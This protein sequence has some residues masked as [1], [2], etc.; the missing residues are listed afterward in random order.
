MLGTDTTYHPTRSF[1]SATELK[2]IQR[3]G[4]LKRKLQPVRA[5]TPWLVCLHIRRSTHDMIGESVAVLIYA[6]SG[7]PAHAA[8]QAAQI[9]RKVARD[10][11]S[12][13]DPWPDVDAEASMEYLD[14]NDFERI[15]KEARDPRRADRNYFAGLPKDPWLVMIGDSDM[16]YHLLIDLKQRGPTYGGS[17]QEDLAPE[18]GGRGYEIEADL[19]PAI[20]DVH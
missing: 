19:N 3:I 6:K 14:D 16:S 15:L 8:T 9:W 10:G 1:F 11:K 17:I 20:E 13:T 7:Q 12:E 5:Y 18:L 2:I 4:T